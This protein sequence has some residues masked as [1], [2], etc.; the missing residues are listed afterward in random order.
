MRQV[1]ARGEVHGEDGV[2]GL[3][4]REEDRLVGL[5]ARVGLDVGEAR[6]EELAGPLDRQRLG[7]VDELAAAVVALAR[8]ALGVL[9]RHHRA[10][11]LEH[12]A[13]DDVLR[14]DQLD[15]V[16]LAAEL[17]PDGGENL[18]VAGG[19]ILA[20]EAAVGQG[21]FH[22]ARGSSGVQGARQILRMRRPRNPEIEPPTRARPMPATRLEFAPPAGKTG[23]SRGAELG[24][25]AH[26]FRGQHG[27]ARP[28]VAGAAGRGARPM[29]DRGR[30]RDRGARRR[31]PHALHAARHRG[32]GDPGL[33]HEPRHRRLP[34]ERVRRG[35][36]EGAARRRR[37]RDPQP[38]PDARD[39]RRRR[40]D[41]RARHQRGLDPARR[42]AGG[43]PA[44]PRRR[45]RAPARA[46]RRRRAPLHPG[47]L[48]RLQLLRPRPH[49][50]HRGRHPRPHPH[51]RLPP[52]PLARRAAAEV[53]AR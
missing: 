9:V 23:L 35:G 2:A 51:G 41:R 42:P 10:L 52:P 16:A 31:R 14:R 6:A 28:G 24:V 27:R 12:G 13:A 45:P 11:R 29:A 33:R 34:D 8:I 53:G 46:R 36:P 1:P 50:P 5:A 32:H 3:Q 47:R 22:R 4:Q 39:P 44:H 18:R 19:E 25:R 26:P 43:A 40:G 15:L 7:H 21:V 20:E 30:R 38:A 48:D 49:P 37:G 17:A